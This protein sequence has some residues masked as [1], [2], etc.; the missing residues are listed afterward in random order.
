[1]HVIPPAPRITLARGSVCIG[2]FATLQDVGRYVGMA[3]VRDLVYRQR[4]ES[5]ATPWY[6]VD[7]PAP[8]GLVVR[9][10]DDITVSWYEVLRACRELERRRKKRDRFETWNGNGPVPGT[11]RRKNYRFMR[12]PRTTQELRLAAGVVFEDDEPEWRGRRRNVPTAYDDI[13]LHRD[14]SWKRHRR[15]QWK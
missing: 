2:V 10:G 1:M 7:L 4:D 3:T 15:T 13:I 9:D 14:H 8:P 11:G 6:A 12:R 5:F